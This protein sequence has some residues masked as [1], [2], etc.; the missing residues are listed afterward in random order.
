[1]YYLNIIIIEIGTYRMIIVLCKQFVR[2]KPAWYMFV[3]SCDGQLLICQTIINYIVGGILNWIVN[4][5]FVTGVKYTHKSSDKEMTIKQ[6]ET[7]THKTKQTLTVHTHAECP[8]WCSVNL[9]ICLFM[10]RDYIVQ[11][12]RDLVKINT[13]LMR[14][15][16]KLCLKNTLN[17]HPPC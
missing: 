9:Y 15:R 5:W 11:S 13:N 14:F 10:H 2:W 4:T 16:L 6:S 8:L 17:K 12:P 7:E 1:M 3:W